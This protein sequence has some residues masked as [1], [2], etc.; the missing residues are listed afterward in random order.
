MRKR[1]SVWAPHRWDLCTHS[2]PLYPFRAAE[3]TPRSSGAC[4]VRVACLNDLPRR[5]DFRFAR[6]F[7]EI[8]LRRPRLS[9]KSPSTRVRN[10]HTPN[11]I[12]YYRMVLVFGEHLAT[13][14]NR[15]SDG[16][17]RLCVVGYWTPSHREKYRDVFAYMGIHRGGAGTL[18]K[19]SVPRRL[20]SYTIHPMVGS[21]K[22]LREE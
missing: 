1:F 12:K 11:S 19:R 3:Y 13:N 17:Q 16:H 18:S 8:Y 4:F 14:R 9:K 20:R 7:C 15:L 5:M 21:L 6:T 10:A 2:F 22:S